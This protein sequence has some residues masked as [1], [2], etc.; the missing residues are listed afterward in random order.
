MQCTPNT[1]RVHA[2]AWSMDGRPHRS[3]PSLF[4][5]T[6]LL[7]MMSSLQVLYVRSNFAV[8]LQH[9][10][11][12]RLDGNFFLGKFMWHFSLLFDK[13]YLIMD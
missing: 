7:Q 9:L 1:L 11:G 3:D 4:C 8:H 5:S 10:L 2:L 12:G 13:I 6:L